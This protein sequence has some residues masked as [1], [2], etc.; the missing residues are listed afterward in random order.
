MPKAAKAGTNTNVKNAEASKMPEKDK[1]GM[2]TEAESEEDKKS[3]AGQTG[4]NVSQNQNAL[5]EGEVWKVVISSRHELETLNDLS[6]R[7]VIV[8][9]KIQQKVVVEEAKEEE[10][11][12]E[13]VTTKAKEKKIT[14][15]KKIPDARSDPIPKPPQYPCARPPRGYVPPRPVPNASPG[16]T[17]SLSSRSSV[18]SSNVAVVSPLPI[19]SSMSSP[20]SVISDHCGTYQGPML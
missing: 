4:E 20:P 5:L 3:D 12:V 18:S 11:V 9:P 15:D 8:T 14:F 17:K 2:P 19:K 16:L 13:K 7:T 10:K 6:N 1:S